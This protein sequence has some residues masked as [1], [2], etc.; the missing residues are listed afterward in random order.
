MVQ[1]ISAHLPFKISAHVCDGKSL[2]QINNSNDSYCNLDIRFMF[3]CHIHSCHIHSDF[4]ICCAML[5]SVSKTWLWL[6]D[7]LG[8]LRIGTSLAFNLRSSPNRRLVNSQ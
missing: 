8:S 3:D 1:V 7:K 5:N 6:I 2:M 4:C